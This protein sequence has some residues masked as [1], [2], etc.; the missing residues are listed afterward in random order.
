M[1]PQK[2][3][4]YEKSDCDAQLTPPQTFHQMRAINHSWTKLESKNKE[5]SGVFW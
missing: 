1:S 3:V 5:Q 2:F 4:I